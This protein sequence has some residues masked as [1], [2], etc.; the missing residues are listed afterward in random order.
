MSILNTISATDTPYYVQKTSSSIS[1]PVG[2]VL[3]AFVIMTPS[4]GS[5]NP[6]SF[7]ENKT[8][9]SPGQN[10]N[11]SINRFSNSATNESIYKTP[12]YSDWIAEYSRKLEDLS[13]LPTNWDSYD[14]EPPN[15]IALIWTEEILN[16]LFIMKF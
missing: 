7:M 2:L 4:Y 8:A 16:V 1:S 11:G 15:E 9:S 6:N 14:A 3:A 13:S 12:K 10:L 5:L